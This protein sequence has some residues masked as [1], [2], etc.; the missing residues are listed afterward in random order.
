MR[1]TLKTPIA[2]AGPLAG[3]LDRVL[4]VFADVKPGEGVTA[5]LLTCNV[6]LLLLAYYL[7]KIV[8]EPLILASGGAEVK[9]YAAVGQAILLVPFVRLYGYLAGRLG[10]TRLITSVTLFFAGNLVLFFVLARA[11]V[12][13]GVPFYL[14]VGIFNL[15]VIA[16]FWSFANDVYSE[17]EGKR[18]FPI[19][20]VGSSVGAVAGSRV[21]KLLIRPFGP[22]SLMLVAAVILTLCLGLTYAVNRRDADRKRASEGTEAFTEAPIGAGGGFALLLR[23]RYLGMVA[24]LTLLLN[25]V[26]TTGE[27]VLDRALVQASLAGGATRGAAERFI[28]EFKA[29]YF[30]WVNV[31]GVI[32]QLFVVSR[33]IRYVG[34]RGALL[35]LPM[36]ALFGYGTL[37]ALPVL[38]IIFVAKVA[39]NSVDYSLQNT[40]RQALFLVTDRE[41][42]YK[43]KA[44][45]DTFVVRAGDVL[46]AA[47]VWL[48]SKAQW[49]TQQFIAMN[50]L[51]VVGWL[52]VVA[53]LGREHVR[54][55]AP[56]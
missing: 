9:T 41:A 36:V 33:V 26:N 7:L 27:Y 18:L 12:R 19:L 24:L 4:R 44:A 48:G 51:L 6:F 3:A 30:S 15:G 49:S 20:G 34:V 31:T 21:A 43:A 28:G 47:V 25:W 8:R 45:I 10:R 1:A 5:L 13:L 56:A 32:L 22:H 11:G 17:A 29:D 40:A 37:A 53:F 54:R 35:V 55:L 50:L 2:P 23:D 14:W 39:E 38:S 46:A 16:Q 52:V 42:K